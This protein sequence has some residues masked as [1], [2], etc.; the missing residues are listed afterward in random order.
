MSECFVTAVF[1]AC[2]EVCVYF[3]L[4]YLVHAFCCTGILTLAI[5]TFSV[6]AVGKIIFHVRIR[7]S[8]THCEIWCSDDAEYVDY[9]LLGCDPIFC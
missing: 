3:C 6:G 8:V 7:G 4:L 1:C 9:G 5:L 2:K